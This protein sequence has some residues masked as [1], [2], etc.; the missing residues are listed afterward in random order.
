M[1][2][3]NKKQ[4]LRRQN[5]TIE[6]E[7]EEGQRR[8]G[9]VS[10]L[11]DTAELPLLHRRISFHKG[12]METEKNSLIAQ[13]LMPIN[14]SN[15]T[16]SEKIKRQSSKEDSTLKDAKDEEEESGKYSLL[17][18]IEKRRRLFPKGKIE[19]MLRWNKVRKIGAGLQNLGNTCFLNSVLQC[20]TYL[21]PL[22]NY[23]LS[24][25]H[26]SYNCRSI[27]LC[28]LCVL[29]KHVCKALAS[30]S[31]IAPYTITKNLKGLG[32]GL[33]LGR[34]EDSHEFLVCLVDSLQKSALSSF[35]S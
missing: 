24:K 9:L 19:E 29:E 15:N 21:P 12:E 2:Q 26:S 7:P 17:A 28:M 11:F 3:Q 5:S 4:Q 6:D 10:K 1:I 30:T 13:R 18:T 35:P 25:D 33:R 8:N 20:L 14:A 32:R 31:S 34:Q 16:S 23:L 27:G 22:A